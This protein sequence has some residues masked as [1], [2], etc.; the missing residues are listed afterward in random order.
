[1]LINDEKITNEDFEKM[2]EQNGNIVK[3]ENLPVM[4]G[5]GDE[6]VW[7]CMFESGLVIKMEFMPNEFKVICKYLRR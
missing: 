2:V 1:M 4:T 5:L 7:K 6:S 3:Y